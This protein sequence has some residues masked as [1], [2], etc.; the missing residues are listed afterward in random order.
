[1]MADINRLMK[2]YVYEGDVS[3]DANVK[4]SYT[5]NTLVHEQQIADDIAK[6]LNRRQGEGH[7]TVWDTND[8]DVPLK[9]LDFPL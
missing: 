2:M 6:T 7:W 9:K 5:F 3:Q 8:M 4:A 1:M